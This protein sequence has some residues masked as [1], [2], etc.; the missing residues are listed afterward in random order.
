MLP[1]CHARSPRLQELAV[2]LA[3]AHRIVLAGLQE[4]FVDAHCLLLAAIIRFVLAR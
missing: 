1:A 2:S 4:I 3:G